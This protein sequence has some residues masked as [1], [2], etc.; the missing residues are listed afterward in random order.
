M[1]E[2]YPEHL[3]NSPGLKHERF[4]DLDSWDYRPEYVDHKVV[5]SESKDHAYLVSKIE[6][7]EKEFQNADL[8]ADTINTYLC[9]CDDFFFNR[10]G[11]ID[12]GE[13]SPDEIG[14]CKHVRAAYK[15]EQAKQDPHQQE[16][17]GER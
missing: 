16:I 10:S 1:P 8:V 3:T 5:P 2:L 17:Y 13:K 9:S 12:T 4:E 14:K 11:G 15:V 7:L 6:V